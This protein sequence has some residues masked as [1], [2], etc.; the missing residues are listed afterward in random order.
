MDSLAQDEGQVGYGVESDAGRRLREAKATKADD[1]KVLMQ[2]WDER[3]WKD[4]TFISDQ[5]KLAKSFN[6]IRELLL[7]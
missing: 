2:L 6:S 5:A 4:W 1:A 3:M 7:M